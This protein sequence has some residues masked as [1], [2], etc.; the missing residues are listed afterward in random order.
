MA[1]V[2]TMPSLTKRSSMWMPTT[3]PNTTQL[4][5]SPPGCSGGSSTVFQCLHSSAAGSP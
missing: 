4:R 3:C 1:P 5:G 2:S